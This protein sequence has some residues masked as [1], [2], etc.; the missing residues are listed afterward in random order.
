[1]ST[2]PDW[3]HLPPKRTIASTLGIAVVELTA[4]RVV[5]TIPVDDETQGSGVENQG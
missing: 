4:E 5:E 1:M 3:I 2:L